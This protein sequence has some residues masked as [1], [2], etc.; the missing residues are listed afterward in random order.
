LPSL[1]IS[2][3][4]TRWFSTEAYYGGHVHSE[5]VD[6]FLWDD[7]PHVSFISNTYAQDFFADMVDGAY[8]VVALRPRTT[9]GG[10]G[11][12]TARR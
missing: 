9:S 11:S 3:T 6:G 12:T 10:I 8:E 7:G 2:V 4:K 5:I 1:I